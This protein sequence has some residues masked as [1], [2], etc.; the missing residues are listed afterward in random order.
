LLCLPAGAENEIHDNVKVLPPKFGL[1]VLEKLAIAKNFFCALRCAGLA[2]MKN[3]YL[4]S[5]LLKPLGRELSDKSAAAD[6]KNF[7]GLPSEFSS[8]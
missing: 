1:M 6:E 3:G 7:H 2:A 8:I 5:A 4:V